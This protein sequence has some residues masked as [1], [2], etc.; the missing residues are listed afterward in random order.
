VAW[1]VAFVV[2]C[3]AE[4]FVFVQVAN[5]VG[6]G[7]AL[8][9]AVGISVAGLFVVKWQGLGVFRRLT[10][11]AREGGSVGPAL[12]DAGM[13]LT[14]G[15]LLLFPGFITGALGLLL[16]VQPVRALLRP[17]LVRGAKK[18]GAVITA[19]YT[20]PLDDTA[21]GGSAV[22]DT[23]ATERP[24]RPAGELERP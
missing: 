20:G 2:L 13:L 12:A 19:T 3:V 4:L 23:T 18:R 5:W 14:A 9:A 22:I 10:D 17:A 1:F 11:S 21:P 15:L 7:W 16:L 8:L 6:F 24:A